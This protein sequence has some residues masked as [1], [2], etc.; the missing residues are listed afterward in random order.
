[1]KNNDLIIGKSGHSI[2]RIEDERLLMGQGRFVENLN[3][4]KQAYLYVVRS[5][6]GHAKIQNILTD[7]VSQLS[8]VLA[9]FTGKDCFNL[10]LVDFLFEMEPQ[11]QRCT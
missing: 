8:G 11:I 5:Y 1:M 2:R 10:D 7:S 3:F 4:P 9:V 6:L